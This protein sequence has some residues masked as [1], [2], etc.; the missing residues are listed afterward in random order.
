MGKNILVID[1]ATAIRQVV[2]LTLRDSGYEVVQAA[3]GRDGLAKLDGQGIDLIICDV[4]MPV[5]NGIEF[6]SAVKN[7]EAYSSYK[8]T[9]IIMLT[10][11]SGDDMKA[12]GKELGA[13][14]WLIKPFKPD[15]LI[16]AV[17][18][19]II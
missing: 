3:D 14:A 5:M 13:R 12:K 11:E 7:D 15:Q 4:N 8:Y 16:E 19:L 17:G 6:L 2:E 10:T 9:P 18:K 1:D